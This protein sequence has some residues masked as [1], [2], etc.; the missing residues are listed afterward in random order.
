M[1]KEIFNNA[2]EIIKIRRFL[3]EN[4]ELSGEEYKTAKYIRSKLDEYGIEYKAS[5]DTGTVA[6]IRGT[7]PGKTVLLRAD[8]DA[9]PVTELSDVDFKSKNDG[10]MHACG[11]DIHTACV[12]YAG[13]ILNDM[14]ETISGN[15]KL[16]FQPRE[17]TD[18]GALPMIEEGLLDN[19]KVDGAFALHVEPL[20][21]CGY[22]QI[23]DGAVMASPDDFIIKII[24]KGGHGA[25]P[26]KC[27]NPISVAAEVVKK[28]HEIPDKYFG[29]ND[30]KCVV[31]ICSISGGSTA[32]VIPNEV[33]ILGTAR[34]LDEKV[35]EKLMKLLEKVA[36][37]TVKDFGADCDFCF[38]KSY[39]PTISDPEMNKIVKDAANEI[40]AIDGVVMLSES[41]MC[42]E[43]FAY[44]AKEVPSSYFKLGVGN[45]EIYEP[46]HSPKFFAD[47]KALPIGV[48]ILVQS[49]LDFLES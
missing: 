11:H 37:G 5:A 8:I 18:G 1:I 30:E 24:G 4:P 9:L 38:N 6:I 39:P 22:I 34:S 2:S 46:I 49:T 25:T 19:P 31:T 36:Y 48:A 7:K 29:K 43:D 44:I 26:E 13:K 40:S 16:M 28:Y 45:S 20:E 33:T 41:S 3:H 21:K 14:K 47:E 23:K 17:E 10:I 35:R 32:N 15:I 42:G 27:I 12:L